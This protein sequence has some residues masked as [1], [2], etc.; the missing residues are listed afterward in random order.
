MADTGAD[1]EAL[2]GYIQ[3]KIGSERLAWSE[4]PWH[5]WVAPYATW[6]PLVLLLFVGFTEPVPVGG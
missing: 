5:A 1:D 2:N 4:V 6:L 3:G